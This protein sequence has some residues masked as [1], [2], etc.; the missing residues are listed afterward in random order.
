MFAALTLPSRVWDR[1]QSPEGPLLH[2]HKGPSP[3]WFLGAGLP[4]G[5]SQDAGKPRPPPKRPG[6]LP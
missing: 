5:C 3:Y 1:L 4:V 6:M 2:W